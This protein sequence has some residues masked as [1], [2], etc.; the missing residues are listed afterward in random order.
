MV[1][2]SLH[3]GPSFPE[4]VDAVCES[5]DFELK[6]SFLFRELDESQF[7]QEYPSAAAKLLLKV[8]RKLSVLFSTTMDRDFRTYTIARVSEIDTKESI[9][10]YT[11]SS[12]PMVDHKLRRCSLPPHHFSPESS[13]TSANNPISRPWPPET[14][15]QTSSSPSTPTSWNG[16]AYIPHSYGKLRTLPSGMCRMTAGQL[17]LSH[18]LL[19]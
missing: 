7:P 16:S 17:L 15:D 19:L 9:V 5:P 12:K 8:L 2:W 6:H 11:L 13:I 3:L 10:F 4:V 14:T 1:E 18:H